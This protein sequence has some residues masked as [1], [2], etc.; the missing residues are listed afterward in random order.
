[1]ALVPVIQP[2]IMK[3]MTTK[4]ERSIVMKQLR[5]VSQKEKIIFPIAVTIVTILLVPSAA[6]LIGM[7]ML[8]N[9]CRESKVVPNLT[10][11][12]ANTL[13]YIITILLGVSVGAKAQ[14]IYFLTPK[15]LGILLLGLIAF[16]FGTFGGVLLGKI[17][18]KLTK[19][20]VNPLIGAAGV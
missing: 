13:M 17:M 6:S 3:L 16:A 5:P 4:Q 20:E 2:P 19:G 7:L 9:L 18:C 1:M 15:T 12:F 8:G 10:N 11:T 14:A